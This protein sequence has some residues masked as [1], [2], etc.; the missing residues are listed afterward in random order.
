MR[1]HAVE[2]DTPKANLLGGAVDLA[3]EMLM[4]RGREELAKAGAFRWRLRP[5]N[6]LGGRPVGSG[7]LLIVLSSSGCRGAIALKILDDIVQHAALDVRKHEGVAGGC[8]EHPAAK[9][10]QQPAAG[11]QH[12]RALVEKHPDIV[13]ILDESHRDPDITVA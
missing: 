12:P 13:E 11:L 10:D 2:L 4:A 5:G 9:L 3:D 1:M 8:I 6:R 7:Q